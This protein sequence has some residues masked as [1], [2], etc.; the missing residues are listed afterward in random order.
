[1]LGYIKLSF[2]Q[3]YKADENGLICGKN[4]HI[5]VLRSQEKTT[6][7]DKNLIFR[8]NKK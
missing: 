1:M 4:W 8:G 2:V 7:R 3:G 6:S 5:M